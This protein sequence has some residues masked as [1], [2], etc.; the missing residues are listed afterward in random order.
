MGGGMTIP[1]DATSLPLADRL[2]AAERAASRAEDELLDIL[3]SILG[4]RWDDFT[5]DYYDRSIEIYG[6]PEDFVLDDAGQL[7]LRE[8]GFHRAWT[9]VDLR[10]SG[11]EKGERAYGLLPKEPT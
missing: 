10:R 3:Q 6:V 7:A 2:W 9:H 1:V 4:D 8:A 11:G 5:T